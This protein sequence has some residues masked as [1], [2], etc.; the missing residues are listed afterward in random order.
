MGLRLG[1][2]KTGWATTVWV[3]P[4]GTT[5]WGVMSVDPYILTCDKP[6]HHNIAH[7]ACGDTHGNENQMSSE[8][9]EL[10]DAWEDAAIGCESFVIRKFLQHREFL[11]PV[12][13]RA[14]IEYGLWLQ[15]KWQADEDDRPMGRGRWLFTQEPSLAKRTLTDERQRQ[16][17][18]WEPGPDHKRDAVKHC[19]TFLQRCQEKPRLRATAWPMLFKNNG[20]LMKKLPPTTKRSKY[21]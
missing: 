2:N 6:I 16:W 17:N 15:E 13:V 7:W 12:R 8:M 4:G 21:Q 18:L 20:D 11:S 3:D 10:Y 19:Y 14:K 5:G 9:L 1:S